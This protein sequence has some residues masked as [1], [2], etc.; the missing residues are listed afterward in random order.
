MTHPATRF[1]PE[2]RH[3]AWRRGS[4]LAVLVPPA[5]PVTA[6]ALRAGAARAAAAGFRSVLSP[7]LEAARTGP[8]L[9]ADFHPHEQLH[10]LHHDLVDVPEPVRDAALRAA[11][12]WDRRRVLAIDAAAFVDPFWHI[13]EL[14][15]DEALHAT[16]RRR[17]RI[18]RARRGY[19]ITG[20]AAGRAYLQRLAV[21]PGAQRAGVGRALVVDALRWSR[22][23]GARR[24]SV[25]TQ[26]ANDA[27]L[28]LYRGLGFS[29]D[30]VGLVV[31]SWDAPT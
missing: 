15:L 23:S 18:D 27:A 29:S 2:M 13:D 22:R 31:L 1:G 8:W 28:A 25:N 6:E 14:G 20:L 4:D 21:A 10:L 5:G 7:A 30:P 9:A 3:R 11:T 17:Y 24:L 12:P 19:A 26:E 16:A